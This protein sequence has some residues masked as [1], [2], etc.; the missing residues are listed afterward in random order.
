MDQEARVLPVP[1]AMPGTEVAMA[2]VPPLLCAPGNLPF[3][4]C[5]R[6]SCRTSLRFLHS[7]KQSG[8]Y[9]AMTIPTDLR[10]P[11]PPADHPGLTWPREWL[12]AVL[13]TLTPTASQGVSW[14]RGRWH[15]LGMEV[16]EDCS[17]NRQPGT[18]PQPLRLWLVSLRP[19][20]ESRAAPSP[21]LGALTRSC[22]DSPR[23][24]PVVVTASL[25]VPLSQAEGFPRQ[26]LV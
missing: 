14:G 7:V 13:K 8:K 23:T 4:T 11:P 18:G 17:R 5:G 19:T 25:T 2:V 1:Q 20:G 24:G 10:I 3:P 15:G 26:C 16:K 9:P 21:G 22:T 6:R 12:R